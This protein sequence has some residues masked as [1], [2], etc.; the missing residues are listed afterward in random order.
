MRDIKNIYVDV[1]N[2]N[3]KGNIYNFAKLSKKQLL[4]YLLKLSSLRNAL[5]RQFNN[6]NKC[7]KLPDYTT[8]IDRLS[9]SYMYHIYSREQIENAIASCLFLIKR[10]RK[11]I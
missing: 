4:K 6:K 1:N 2:S 10:T 3:Y 11:E 7:I 5:T 8:R 9:F